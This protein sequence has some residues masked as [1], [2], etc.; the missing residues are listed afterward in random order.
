MTTRSATFKHTGYLLCLLPQGLL[1]LGTWLQFP[2]LS[3]LFF[4][5]ALPLLRIVIGND[6]SPPV[7]AGSRWLLFYLNSIPRLYCLAWALVMPWVIWTLATQSM[8]FSA[9]LGFGLSLWIVCSL[10]T[11]VAHELLHAPGSVDKLLG[12]WLDASIGYVH[13]A[14][15]HLSHHARTGYY[16]G[17]DAAMPGVSLYRYAIR[18]YGNSLVTAWEVETSRLRRMGLP[19][20]A[21]RLLRKLPL[22]MGI[23]LAFYGFAGSTGFIMYLFQILGS[24]LTIQAITYLQH[25]GL[26]QRDTPEQADYGFA[27]EDGCWMQACVTLNHAY[28]GRHHLHPRKRYYQLAWSN[29]RL[30]LPGSYPVMFI[31]A[32]FPAF[33]TRVMR[34]RLAAWRA[35]VNQPGQHAHH[36][37]CINLSKPS[38]LRT[39]NPS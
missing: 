6:F 33:F 13:F 4:F 8:T 18:R 23:G 31:V 39:K 38:T 28:H 37:D 14:E 15:E 34:E 21:N 36:A 5:V 20:H 2:W 7:L 22:P 12:G 26:S 30:A 19:W 35:N 25:W 1:V 17:G 11:A 16:R 3:V 24:A 32:L 10:N 27:W 9:C 29:D